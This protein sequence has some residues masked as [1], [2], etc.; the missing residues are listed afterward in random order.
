MFEKKIGEIPLSREMEKR[1]LGLIVG[2]LVFLVV[3]ILSITFS[4]SGSFFSFKEMTVNRFMIKIPTKNLDYEIPLPEEKSEN[5]KSEEKTPSEGELKAQ[6]KNLTFEEVYQKIVDV[7]KK[8]PFIVRF[9]KVSDQENNAFLKKWGHHSN[10]IDQEYMLIDVE[11]LKEKTLCLDD[12]TRAFQDIHP[13]IVVD[14]NEKLQAVFQLL[15]VS[16]K[17]FSLLLVSIVTFCILL[18]VTLIT[19]AS[20]KTHF[21]IIDILRLL[22]AKNSYIINVYQIQVIKSVFFGSILGSFCALPVLYITKYLIDYCGLYFFSFFILTIENLQIF[23]IVPFFMAVISFIVTRLVVMTELKR[24]S[25][26]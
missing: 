16:L 23:L 24:F 17:I 4:I 21:S 20:L 22:G 7:L 12:L 14:Y 10:A 25:H 11:F 19:R 6:K 1:H 2:I 5:L 3:T 26:F 15:T 18:L 9:E 13:K 8:T